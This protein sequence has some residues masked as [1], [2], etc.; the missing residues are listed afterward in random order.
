MECVRVTACVNNHV[1]PSAFRSCSGLPTTT[2]RSSGSSSGGGSYDED[3]NGPRLPLR[4]NLLRVARL[5]G[6][7]VAPAPAGGGPLVPEVPV[8]GL[9]DVGEPLAGDA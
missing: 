9:E 7:R 4:C 3:R 6:A 5:A 2:G 8:P 1:F